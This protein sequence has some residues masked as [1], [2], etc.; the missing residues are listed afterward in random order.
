M[1]YERLFIVYV[2]LNCLQKIKRHM[3]INYVELELIDLA[4]ISITSLF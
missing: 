3:F 4:H 2:L 1:F